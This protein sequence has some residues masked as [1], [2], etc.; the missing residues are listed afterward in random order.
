M[1]LTFFQH[2]SLRAGINVC[3]LFLIWLLTLNVAWAETASDKTEF[4]A[5][6][7]TEVIPKSTAVAARI[8]EANALLSETDALTDAYDSLAMQ[9]QQLQ[10][11]EEQFADW[12]DTANWPLNRLMSADARYKEINQQQEKTLETLSDRLS[13]MEELRKTWTAEK[14]YWQDW[15]KALQSSDIKIPEET[16]QKTRQGIDDL[17][18]RVAK[19]S[20]EIVNKQA[21]GRIRR[22]PGTSDQPPY[23]DQQDPGRTSPVNVPQEHLFPLQQGLLQAINTG[24]VRS[25]P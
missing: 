12:E 10:E 13:M 6:G 8:T 7:L 11:L 22:S 9:E 4:P 20:T 3:L 17:L 15:K 18:Q 21:T 16:F 23:V 5:T 24:V 14:E 2:T 19:A 25:I 1:K